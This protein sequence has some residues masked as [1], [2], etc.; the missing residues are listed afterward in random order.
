MA[1]DKNF[2]N[3]SGTLSRDCNAP[4]VTKTGRKV[5]FFS[6]TCTQ[7]NYKTFVDCIAWNDNAEVIA[8]NGKIGT[9]L[10]VLG[11][12][13]RMKNAK[14]GVYDTKINITKVKEIGTQDSADTEFADYV[15]DDDVPF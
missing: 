3:V 8:R 12:I 5:L 9:H 14:T 7:G 2:V 1:D 15:N 6:L 13:T 4:T 10:E 11:T